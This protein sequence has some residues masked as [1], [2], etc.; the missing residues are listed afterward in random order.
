MDCIKKIKT[1]EQAEIF[2]SFLAA[3]RNRHIK[4]ILNANRDLLRLAEKFDIEIPWKNEY[5]VEV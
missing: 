2:A 5:F 4:D 3:E 1:K